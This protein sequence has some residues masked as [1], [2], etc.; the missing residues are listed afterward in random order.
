MTAENRTRSRYKISISI[1]RDGTS[2]SNKAGIVEQHFFLINDDDTK[3]REAILGRLEIIAAMH[4]WCG[5]DSNPYSMKDK[6]DSC[7]AINRWASTSLSSKGT[8]RFFYST[9]SGDD[10]ISLQARGSHVIVLVDDKRLNGKG[11]KWD[12]DFNIKNQMSVTIILKPENTSQNPE[13]DSTHQLM[14]P[15]KIQVVVERQGVV[16]TFP[17]P[18]PQEEAR[19]IETGDTEKM[20]TEIRPVTMGMT[21]TFPLSTPTPQVSPDSTTDGSRSSLVLPSNKRPSPLIS[22]KEVTVF[23]VP[24]GRELPSGRRKEIQKM[25]TRLDISVTNNVMDATHLII[26]PDVQSI[27]EVAKAARISDLALRKMLD[28]VCLKESPKLSF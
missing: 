27:E 9:S 7:S 3:Q 13:S 12:G 2:S 19:H 16:E 4:R 6:C 24:L 22:K 26:S 23:F 1:I 15:L 18:Y 5:C 28:E 17:N 21:G 25:A 8:L 20:E 14:I 11:N 10:E